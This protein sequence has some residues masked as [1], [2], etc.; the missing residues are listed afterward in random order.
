MAS[1]IQKNGNDLD[2]I[3]APYVTGEAKAPTTGIQVNGVDLNSRYTKLS[4]GTAPAVTHIESAGTDLDGILAAK[5]TVLKA[6]TL[7]TSNTHSTTLST[8]NEL[9][10]TA[11]PSGSSTFF[12]SAVDEGDTRLGWGELE[13]QFH[14]AGWPQ[15]GSI[16]SPTGKGFLWDATTLVGTNIAAGTWTPTVVLEFVATAE[17][18]TGSIHVRAFKRSS[19][20]VYTQIVNCAASVTLT[21]GNLTVVNSGWTGNTGSSVSFATGDKLYV[22]YMFDITANS[23][24]G[25][26]DLEAFFTNGSSTQLV[27]PGYVIA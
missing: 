18:I 7:F 21:F 10:L 23:A 13:A 12:G 11:A 15:F 6:L 9:L 2:N 16:P 20:G 27:T 19:A 8:A 24:S 4:L 25:F 3:L 17:G 5:G 1:G 14:S 26:D 22:D